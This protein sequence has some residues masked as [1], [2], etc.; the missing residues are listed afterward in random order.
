MAAPAPTPMIQ[1]GSERNF[2]NALLYS[3]FRLDS[4][5]DAGF[6]LEERVARIPRSVQSALLQQC[7][8]H[9]ALNPA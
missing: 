7:P 8:A 5:W 6:A 4:C 9:F 1:S 2:Q 3:L